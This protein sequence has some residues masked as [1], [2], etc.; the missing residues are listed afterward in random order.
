[1][2]AFLGNSHL[3]LH[4]FAAMP[5]PSWFPAYVWTDYR[6]A[7]LF[8]VFVPLALMIWA[9]VQKSEGIQRLLVI[10]WR[11]A[12]LLAITVYLLIG[13]LPIG[14]AAGWLARILIPV[15][16][17]FWV[18][19]NEEIAEQPESQL[20]LGFMAWRWAVSIYC[21]LGVLVQLPLLR[22]AVMTTDALKAD[23]LCRP[24]LEVPWAFREVFHATTKPF[25]LGFLGIIGLVVYA[26]SLAYFVFVRLGKQG[27]SALEQ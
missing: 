1:V 9:L 17:W 26:I 3:Y 16:L 5:I 25:F 19:L 14:F 12:S 4:F 18:D 11:V 13:A 6:L 10:Y 8:T 21:F 7:L 2:F 27:R 22:C 24:W 15:S 23:G 20:K